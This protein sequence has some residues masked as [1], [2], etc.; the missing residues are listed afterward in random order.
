MKLLRMERLRPLVTLGNRYTPR[1]F[2]ASQD[3]SQTFIFYFFH[4][5]AS[6]STC[7][8][9]M[10]KVMGVLFSN[11][12]TSCLPFSVPLSFSHLL[13]FHL[14]MLPYSSILSIH[15]LLLIV[16]II[17]RRNRTEACHEFLGL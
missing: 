14:S 17:D 7:E 11:S 13:F 4:I 9:N 2:H 6:K 16:K 15:I 5:Y 10:G 1:F 8:K 12:F 3:I